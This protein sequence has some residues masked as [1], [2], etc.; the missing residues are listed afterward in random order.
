MN[1]H[2][3]WLKKRLKS[4]PVL[5]EGEKWMIDN[6]AA[7]SLAD[8][9]LSGCI[10]TLEVLLSLDALPTLVHFLNDSK[11]DIALRTQ[12]AKAIATIGSSYVEIDL[13]ALLSSHSPE[14]S[15]LAKIALNRMNTQEL[16]ETC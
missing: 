6:L 15:L 13:T 12:A 5:D 7:G 11:H 1:D 8:P 3:R 9:D 16:G 14:L 10:D 4:R 2:E